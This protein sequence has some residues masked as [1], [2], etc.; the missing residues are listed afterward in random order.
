MRVVSVV[1]V[2]SFFPLFTSKILVIFPND[3]E[4]LLGSRTIT[5][6]DG[7]QSFSGVVTSSTPGL[8]TSLKECLRLRVDC[9]PREPYT[10]M[11]QT[12]MT[13]LQT[14]TFKPITNSFSLNKRR[15][16]VSVCNS[17]LLTRCIIPSPKTT[18][19]PMEPFFTT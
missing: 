18:D 5:D 17:I 7:N 11:K 12:K 9:Y 6:R 1:D 4:T 16:K 15:V 8:C 3:P 19:A 13:T 14:S 2:E 10:E